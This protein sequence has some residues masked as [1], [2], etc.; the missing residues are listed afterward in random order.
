MALSG[1]NN[2]ADLCYVLR[3]ETK[4]SILN[5]HNLQSLSSLPWRITPGGTLE[6]PPRPS[7]RFRIPRRRARAPHLSGVRVSEPLPL[8]HA[9]FRTP[10]GAT[11]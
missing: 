5:R 9:P 1:E 10:P 8:A 6:S 7:N 11:V 4:Q 3:L 2:E